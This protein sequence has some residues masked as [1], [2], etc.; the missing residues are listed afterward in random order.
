M[1]FSTVSLAIASLATHVLAAP[2]LSI[3]FPGFLRTR[4][5]GVNLLTFTQAL[6]S[7]PAEPVTSTTDPKRPF[8]VGGETFTDFRTAA[9][10]SCNNQHNECAKVANSKDGSNVDGIKVGDCDD[11][12]TQCQAAAAA[13][14]GTG[15]VIPSASAAVADDASV[16]VSASAAEATLHSSDENFFYFCDP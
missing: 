1:K 12:Q 5:D 11:Q 2:D 3:S 15:T 6:A 7:I 13:G 16:V 9:T 8:Q 14:P 4:A 10:R